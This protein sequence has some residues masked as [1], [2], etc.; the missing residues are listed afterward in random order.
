[1]AGW[2]DDRGRFGVASR[3]VKGGRMDEILRNG[4]YRSPALENAF[5]EPKFHQ[6]VE[7]VQRNEVKQGVTTLRNLKVRRKSSMS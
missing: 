4:S 3:N 5:G 7:H 1:M 2:R 6:N